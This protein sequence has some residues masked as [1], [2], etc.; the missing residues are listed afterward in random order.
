MNDPVDRAIR[1]SLA[2]ASGKHAAGRNDIAQADMII[3]KNTADLA[4]AGNEQSIIHLLLS[5]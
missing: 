4:R 2:Y 1:V 5:H 3:W